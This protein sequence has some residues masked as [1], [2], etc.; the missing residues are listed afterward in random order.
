MTLFLAVLAGFSVAAVTTPVGVSGAVLL[1]PVQLSVLGLHGPAVSATNLLYNVVAT[2][3]GLSRLARSVRGHGTGALVAAGAAVPCA[4][5]GAAVRVTWLSDPALFRGLLAVLMLGMGVRLLVTRARA[6]P[7]PVAGRGRART[8]PL[9]LAAGGAALLGSAVGI[10]GGSLLAPLLIAVGG[11]YTSR[12]ALVGLTTTLVTSA[13]GLGAYAVFDRIGF[14]AAPAAPDWGVGLA[15]GAGGALGALV[16]V[17]L[18]R[19]LGERPLRFLLGGLVSLTGVA[20][21]AGLLA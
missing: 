18:G 2:P 14:G 10:G 8:V 20:Y 3:L 1:L 19:R 15:L 5:A 12:A 17:T 13:A 6:R 7:A 11:W 4:V 21:L 16:G 9:A